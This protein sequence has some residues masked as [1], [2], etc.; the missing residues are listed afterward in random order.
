MVL[1]CLKEVSLGTMAEIAYDGLRV[2]I[3]LF[4]SSYHFTC[5]GPSEVTNRYKLKMYVPPHRLL[6]LVTD[7][8]QTKHYSLDNRHL[9]SYLGYTQ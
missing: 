4:R 8:Y 9:D 6:S 7:H 2:Y 3:I 1:C 5:V